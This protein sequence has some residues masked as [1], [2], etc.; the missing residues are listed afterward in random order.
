[1]WWTSEVVVMVSREKLSAQ[2]SLLGYLVE[3]N[4]DIW[5]FK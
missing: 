2:D 4:K 5:R 1:M 3:A